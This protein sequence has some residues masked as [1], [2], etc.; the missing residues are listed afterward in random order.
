MVRPQASP[1]N[2]E[3]ALLVAKVITT[4]PSFI[5]SPCKDTI[6]RCGEHSMYDVFSKVCPSATR[7][8]SRT[9]VTEAELNKVLEKDG[10]LRVRVRSSIRQLENMPAKSCSF[11]SFGK[12][13]W[14]NPDD[15]DDMAAIA[16]MWQSVSQ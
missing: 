10:F 6:G 2:K 14:R 16:H 13:R 9:G 8:H 4:T 3:L 1:R 5:R 12:R 11:Y 7:D 15:A